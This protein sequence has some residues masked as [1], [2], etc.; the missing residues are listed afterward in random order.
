MIT[1]SGEDSFSPFDDLLAGSLTSPWGPDQ[2]YG[3][4][5]ELLEGLL[6]VPVARGDSWQSGRF[7]KALDVWIAQELRRAGLGEDEVWPRRVRP[8]VLAPA[9]AE[10]QRSLNPPVPAPVRKLL[11]GSVGARLFGE[12][13]VKQVDVALADWDRGAELI[14]STKSQLSSFGNNQKNRFE[15]A[16]GDLRNLRGRYPLAALGFAYL[17]RS[18]ILDEKGQWEFAQDMTRK[19]R[20]DDRGYD[21]TVLLVADWD[22][23]S[24][25]VELL[26]DEVPEDLGTEQFF[27]NLLGGLLERTPVAFHVRARELYEDRSLGLEE[28]VEPVEDPEESREG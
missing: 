20:L 12:F 3:P 10:L 27:A 16:V 22:D 26:T 13:Y 4:D 2:S 6:A 18:T 9:L 14:V 1:P 19:L 15:E 21:A 28:G 25:E 11:K 5:H 23:D 17:V 8:R 7:I 24:G